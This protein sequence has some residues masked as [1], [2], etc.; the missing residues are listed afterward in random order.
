MRAI[1]SRQRVRGQRSAGDDPD[2]IGIER[3]DFFAADFDGRLRFDR[4]RDFGG[5]DLA[6]DGQ[7]VARGDAGARRD[8]ADQQRAQAAQFFFQ[9][10]GRAIFL[11]ALERIAAHQLGQVA[12]LVRRRLPQRAHFVK[13]RASAGAR[14]LPRRL[15]S[16]QATAD[17]MNFSHCLHY[18]EVE[19][20]APAVSSLPALRDFEF[21]RKIVSEFRC[22][23]Q[24][25]AQR[26]IP[27][28][29]RGRPA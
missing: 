29:R 15:A 8:L 14:H 4:A 6:I 2:V 5:E 22:V 10:P 21:R 19:L 9:Q 25:T 11:F 7:R 26:I 12:G 20:S 13:H 3:S 16:G 27:T 24:G 18:R 17:D 23:H 1:S 28:E